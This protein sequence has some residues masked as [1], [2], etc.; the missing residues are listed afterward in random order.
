MN[1]S[2]RLRLMAVSVVTAA[3]AVVSGPALAAPAFAAQPTGQVALV[4]PPTRGGHEPTFADCGSDHAPGSF[5]QIS[6]HAQ[7]R[8]AER[9]VSE[10]ELRNGVRIGARTAW[11]QTNGSWRYSL[12]MDG[13]QLEVIIGANKGKWVVVTVFWKGEQY[14]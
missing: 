10:D 9:G 8:M 6:Q 4:N 7:Q 12:G 5:D 2:K 3:V 14:N 1:S 13:G 11:C